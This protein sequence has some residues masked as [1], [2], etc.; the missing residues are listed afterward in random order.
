MI[1]Q[2]SVRVTTE[3][4]SVR[5]LQGGDIAYFAKDTKA[6]WE[7]DDYVRKIAFVRHPYSRQ[8]RMLRGVLARMKS[9]AVPAVLSPKVLGALGAM[10]PL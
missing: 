7:I 10:I 9:H 5:T 6:L 1:L 4:G 3:D 8:V 2:G